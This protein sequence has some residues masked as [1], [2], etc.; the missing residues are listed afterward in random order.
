MARKV[1]TKMT[2]KKIRDIRTK[3]NV[4]WMKVLEIAMEADPVRTK[5]V[6]Q[7]ITDNDRAI[8]ALTEQLAQ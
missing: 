2:I 6:L 5:K 3:N 4:H 7:A 1:S 8:S